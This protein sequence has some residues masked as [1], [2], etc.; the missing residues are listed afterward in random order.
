M[1]GVTKIGTVR[2]PIKP[3]KMKQLIT[4]VF[5]LFVLSASAQETTFKKFFNQ[6]SE[7]SAFS[8]NLN[9]SFAGSFL[10][11]SDQDDLGK[12]L[13]NSGDFKLMVFKNDD[14][15]IGKDF[16]K[17]VKKNNLKTMARMKSEKNRAAFY[18]LEKNDRIKEIVLHAKTDEDQLVLFGLKTNLT[19]DELAEMMSNSNIK[20]TE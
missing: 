14:G 10:S 15:E 3:S 2:L 7:K 11:D 16:K 19:T 12:L 1:H 17:Y 9:A 4:F 20:I 18:V 6:H 8:I 13:K 5:A